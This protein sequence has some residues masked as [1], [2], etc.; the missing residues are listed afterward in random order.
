MSVERILLKGGCVLTLDPDIGNYPKG[1]VLIEDNK[2]AAVGP[3]LR[4]SGAEVIDA[5]NTIVMPGFIDTHRHIWEGIL[6][7]IAPDALL[8]EYFRDIL[9]VL[10]IRAGELDLNYLRRWA[11]ELK[12]VDILEHALEESK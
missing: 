5:T 2:I 8:D 9:G 3:Q 1:D 4:V 12:V 6:K 11:Q 10:K 7:N